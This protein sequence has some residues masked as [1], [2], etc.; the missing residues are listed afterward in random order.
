MSDGVSS[1]LLTLPEAASLLHCSVDTLRRWARQNR[2]RL[3]RVPGGL[4][5][6]T[7]EIERLL[8]GEPKGGESGSTA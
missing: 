5:V 8:H 2:L 7:V 3:S 6:S 1:K 4:R